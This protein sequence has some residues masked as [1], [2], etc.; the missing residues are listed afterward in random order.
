MFPLGLVGRVIAFLLPALGAPLAAQTRGE[1][2]W[3]WVGTVPVGRTFTIDAVRANVRVVPA[4][5]DL[6]EVTAVLRGRR[7]APES[8]IMAVDTIAGSV[9]IRTRYASYPTRK[10][11]GRDGCPPPDTFHGNFWYS[12]V[13]ADLTLRVPPGVRVAIHLM[14]GDIDAGSGDEPDGAHYPERLHRHAGRRGGSY[15]KRSHSPRPVINLIGRSKP[16]RRIR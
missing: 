13:H 9:V 2:K 10:R 7:D 5:G 15:W 14:W 11:S 8:V 16:E 4:R 3:T 6:L 12:D 1:A